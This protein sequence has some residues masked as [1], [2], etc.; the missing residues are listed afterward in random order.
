MTPKWIPKRAPKIALYK[1]NIIE[2]TLKKLQRIQYGITLYPSLNP[3]RDAKRFEKES[4]GTDEITF[5]HPPTHEKENRN[6]ARPRPS[7]FD[8]LMAM[9]VETNPPEGSQIT[10]PCLAFTGWKR[11]SG[12]GRIKHDGKMVSAHRV[13]YE[14]KH[15]PIPKGMCVMHLCDNPACCNPDHLT[16]GTQKE[17]T[18]DSILKGRSNGTRKH[19]LP[20]LLDRICLLRQSGKTPEQ[21]AKET[22]YSL[23]SIRSILE[24]LD[25]DEDIY[26]P[27]LA[28]Y[29]DDLADSQRL[30]RFIHDQHTLAAVTSIFA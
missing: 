8:R 25:D 24:F 3:N 11:L 4:E 27:T 10:T 15:G 5:T 6:M 9:C 26:A 2:I 23:V 21:I 18:H 20:N 14:H 12:H 30:E 19:V 28:H 29:G 22:G 1:D 7:T 13:A 16:L 17:N